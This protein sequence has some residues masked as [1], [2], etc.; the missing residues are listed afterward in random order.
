MWNPTIKENNSTTTTM[1]SPSSSSSISKN[2]LK[3]LNDLYVNLNGNKWKIS[4]NWKTMKDDPC[5][6]TQPYFGIKCN[7]YLQI[8]E[9]DLSNNNL[10]G[11]IPSSISSFINLKKLILNNNKIT[12]EIPS[13]LKNIQTLQQIDISNNLIQV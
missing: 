13:S 12:G 6:L 2:E 9:I 7:I 3:A 4:T 11:I 8:I 5:S 10:N 1:T